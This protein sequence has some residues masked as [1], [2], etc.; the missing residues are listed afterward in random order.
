[1]PYVKVG[2]ILEL[3]GGNM[4][5]RKSHKPKGIHKCFP[6]AWELKILKC[7]TDHILWFV[8][9][10]LAIKVSVSW[11]DPAGCFLWGVLESGRRVKLRDEKMGINKRGGVWDYF[12]SISKVEK[13]IDFSSETRRF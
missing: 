12:L 8:P 4:S 13:K 7:K 10:L 9:V 6:T 3:L 11:P 5:P 1:M 2:D